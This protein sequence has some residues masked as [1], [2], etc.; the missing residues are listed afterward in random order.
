MQHPPN[1]P[2]PNATRGTNTSKYYDCHR[3][4]HPLNEGIP[5]RCSSTQSH[6]QLSAKSQNY[7]KND[8]PTSNTALATHDDNT[9][10][11]NT[12]SAQKRSLQLAPATIKL[13][14]EPSFAGGGATEVSSQHHQMLFVSA[15]CLDMSRTKRSFFFC[16]MAAWLNEGRCPGGRPSVS[17]N[18]KTIEASG[19]CIEM[20][21]VHAI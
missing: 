21:T 16:L 7:Q 13:T 18:Y 4:C 10:S 3:S 8:T 20:T 6:H 12:A 11:P 15:R 19:F 5:S 9:T 14:Y 2:R 17:A 1:K